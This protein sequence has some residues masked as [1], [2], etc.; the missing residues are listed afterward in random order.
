MA[1][2]VLIPTGMD[3][4]TEH[5]LSQKGYE[6]VSYDVEGTDDFFEQAKTADG[7][8]SM[9]YPYNSTT[10]DRVPN[11]K[12]I[13]R[14]GVGYDSVDTKAAG[15]RGIWVTNTP[16][17]NAVTVAESTIVDILLLSKNVIQESQTLRDG[18][19][20]AGRHLAGHD[21][22]GKT[23]GIVGFGHI[24]QEV[25]KRLQ[26]FGMTILYYN[27]S[28]KPSEYGQQVTLDELLR[29]SDFV[30]L[31]VPATPETHHLIGAAQLKMMKPTASLVNFAR[32]AVVDE[33]A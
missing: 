3:Q 9:T 8:V 4:L 15:Q 5:Y 18:N 11:V 25:A 20:H 23:V 33:L 6:L 12:I 17:S 21:L 24:G 16:G 2:K 13:A 14:L 32:G 28:Q 22:S 27:R 10:L 7:I 29:K 19:W 1:K 26:A 31:H 30:S